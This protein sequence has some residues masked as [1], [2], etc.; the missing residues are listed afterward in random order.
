MLPIKQMLYPKTTRLKNSTSS[1]VI[2]EKLDG[3][4]LTFFKHNGELYF[5]QRNNIFMWEPDVDQKALYKGLYG[6][7]VENG[8]KLK[9]SL[10]DKSAV[11]GEW[12]GM[13][14][15]S[16][17]DNLD[18]RFYIFAKANVDVI[19]DKFKMYNIIYKQM[20]FIYPFVDQ[21]IPEFMDIVPIVDESLVAPSVSYMDDLYDYYRA[22]KNYLPEGFIVILPTQNNVFKYVRNKDGK[23][24]DHKS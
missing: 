14:R 20:L 9:D 7:L 17:G 12:I 2:T 6:W 3:S 4:N 22:H 8:D 18:K 24:Q 15:I 23:L 1:Y 16:Y 13:G 11:V 19:D 10:N 5:A 21:V